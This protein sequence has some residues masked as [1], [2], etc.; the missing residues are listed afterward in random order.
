[1][2]IYLL[3]I[4][5]LIVLNGI[6]S[7]CETAIISV[8]KSKLKSMVK[9]KKDK[10]AETV[11]A[12]K[13]NP[14]RFLSSVQIGITLFGTFASAL[15]GIIAVEKIRPVFEPYFGRFS[16]PLSLAF[17]VSCMTYAF[18]VF[19][20]LV[21][22]SIGLSHN[23]K[24]SKALV[25]I[26][27]FA[28]KMFFF[29]VEL[30]SASTNLVL[31]FIRQK[32]V[33]ETISEGEIRVMIEEG[34]K[35]GVIDT[36]EEQIFHGVFKFA[37]KSVKEIMVPKPKVYS[38][39]IKSLPDEVLNYIVENE[40]SRYPVF[41]EDKD[42]IVGVVYYKDVIREMYKKGG[43][44][45]EKIVKKPYFV[46]ETMEISQLFKEMQKRHVHMA[47]V[48]NEYGINVGI[49]TL[50]DIIEEIFGEIMDETDVEEDIERMKDGSYV[51]DASSMVS[52]LNESLGLDLPESPDYETLGGFIL[53]KLGEIPKGGEVVF[54]GNLK[55]T[56][57]AMEGRRIS[58][59]RI[60]FNK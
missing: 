26:I 8:Q 19:G 55:L 54:H 32:R 60:E 40:F 10:K 5:V 16:E 52:D 12:I 3:L 11:L 15:A 33:E 36:T 59:V 4:G 20:E 37:K 22:K 35:R 34:R 7:A 48:V 21:P 18:L 53:K 31:R 47:I 45:L 58:K 41:R 17:C 46:P 13:E 1:M 43:F 6:F 30:L 27:I 9:E 51:V 50:E 28:S 42:N 29:F 2:G 25:P 38:I 49:V 39:D 44:E 57:L 24:V 56:V 14:Q 23:E